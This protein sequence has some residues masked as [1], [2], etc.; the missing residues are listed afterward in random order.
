[1]GEEVPRKLYLWELA[2]IAWWRMKTRPT[3]TEPRPPAYA[4]IRWSLHMAWRSIGVSDVKILG[5]VA[6]QLAYIFGILVI[7]TFVGEKS[8]IVGEMWPHLTW[9]VTGDYLKWS[10]LASLMISA[11]NLLL[12]FF[13][14]LV[15]DEP[16][17]WWNYQKWRIEHPEITED[18][19]DKSLYGI[20]RKTQDK[21]GDHDRA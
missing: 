19:L 12:V 14:N 18:S 15:F 4:R 6:S 2:K 1:M 7:L 21:E 11:L 10:A 17:T 3:C 13:W 9:G 8:G 5:R 20:Y 16:Y